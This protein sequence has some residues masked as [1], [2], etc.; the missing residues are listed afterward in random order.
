MFDSLDFIEIQKYCVFKYEKS[1]L[2]LLLHFFRGKKPV[3]FFFPWGMSENTLFL[4]LYFDPRILHKIS[5][6]GSGFVKS[7]GRQTF[8]KSRKE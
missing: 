1:F 4:K 2:L 6:L 3:I 5:L 7:L 8:K